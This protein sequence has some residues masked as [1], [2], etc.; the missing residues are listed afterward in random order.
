M[1][2]LFCKAVYYG[3]FVGGIVLGLE[4]A[5]R[6]G[7]SL[8]AVVAAFACIIAGGALAYAAG[9]IADQIDRER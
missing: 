3:G 9:K 4:V 2:Y 8:L 1:E 6:L 5:R 7:G